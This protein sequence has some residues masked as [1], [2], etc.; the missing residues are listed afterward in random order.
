MSH[1]KTRV[2]HPEY[3]V[4]LME[5]SD[6]GFPTDRIPIYTYSTISTSP[7]NAE[8]FSY[9]PLARSVSVFITSSLSSVRHRRMIG[10]KFE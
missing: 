3:A 4:R 5:G 10:S 1:P 8:K 2:I 7:K 9:I 6:E